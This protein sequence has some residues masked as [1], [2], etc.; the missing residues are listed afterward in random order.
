MAGLLSPGI[1]LALVT[2][3]YKVVEVLGTLWFTRRRSLRS[4]HSPDPSLPGGREGNKKK[5]KVRGWFLFFSLLSLWERRVGVVR[6]SEARRAR[7]GP[8]W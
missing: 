8:G 5:K 2:G 3:R 6:A 1:S 7:G 4:P